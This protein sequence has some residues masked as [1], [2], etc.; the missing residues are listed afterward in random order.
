MSPSPVRAQLCQAKENGA[1]QLALLLDPD[2]LPEKTLDL[3]IDLAT[4]A[5]V[6]YFLIG[7]SL[8]VH[9]GHDAVLTHIRQRSDIPLILFPGSSF[10]LSYRA[11]AILFLSL[12]SGRNPELLIGQHVITAP[13]LRLS[14]LEIISCGYMLIE[15]GV[16]TAVQYISNTNPIPANKED[17]AVCTAM[18]GEM[19][20]LRSIYLEAGSGA[21][22]AVPASMIEAVVGTISVPLIVGGGIRSA[23]QAETAW[24]AGADLIVVGNA[25][26]KQ[27]ELIPELAAAIKQF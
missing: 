9:S 4:Q 16:T 17:I 22:S 2:K 6:H 21:K 3:I 18:A 7:S 15:G 11:D 26:E 24:K 23:Q 10:Q 1:K 13:F 5:G 19:L 8:M 20:G 25:V 14:S 27:P 12:I